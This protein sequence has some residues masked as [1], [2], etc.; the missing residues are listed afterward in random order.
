M[1]IDLALEEEEPPKPSDE[2][3]ESEIAHHKAWVKSNKMCL[4]I[5]KH[6]IS[7]TI[8]GVMPK[9]EKAKVFMI[10]I[11]NRFK[12]SDKAEVSS[13]LGRLT[14]ASYN[15]HGNIREYIVELS[16]VV[17]KIRSFGLK[18]EDELLAYLVLN[19]LPSQFSTFQ[20]NYNTQK[21]KWT[22]NELISQCVQEE[23]RLS[24]QGKAHSVHLVTSGQGR[25]GKKK[26]KQ[27]SDKQHS[28]SSVNQ[29]Q[30]EDQSSRKRAKKNNCF[31]CKKPGHQKKGLH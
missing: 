4:K 14:H 6:S 22:L 24:K 15:D 17:S 16:D 2:S 11:R 30:P 5:M 10:E 7:E 31:F 19:S 23:E 1:D 18:I 26:R 28:G 21:D 13:L 29:H 20:V 9:T 27:G 25:N 8:K 12:R 3:T